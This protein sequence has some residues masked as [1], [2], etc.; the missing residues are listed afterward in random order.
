MASP[1]RIVNLLMWKRLT[2]CVEKVKGE[3]NWKLGAKIVSSR[4]WLSFIDMLSDILLYCYQ[5]TLTA[6]PFRI[7]NL[8]IWKRLT[9]CVEKV[10]GE[11]NWELGI[12]SYSGN[13]N[14]TLT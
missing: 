9:I 12:M 6:S 10:R 2:I 1:F 8:L 14:M 3:G 7:V 13:M 5:V 4:R 11:G